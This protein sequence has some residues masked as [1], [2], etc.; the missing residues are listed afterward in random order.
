MMKTR[1]SFFLLGFSVFLLETFWIKSGLIVLGSTY[2]TTGLVLGAFFLGA[3][4]GSFYFGRAEFRP[5][6]YL[7]GLVGA[8][9][10]SAVPAPNAPAMFGAILPAC[11]L[12]A[13]LFPIAG[14]ASGGR[15]TVELYAFNALGAVIGILAG[16]Y[17]LPPITGYTALHRIGAAA[18]LLAV[19]LFVRSI[20][21]PRAAQPE[22]LPK[23]LLPAF[24][25][26]FLTLMM[27]NV[28]IRQIS[29]GT[30]N[31]VFAFGCVTL[32]FTLLSF[33]TAFTIARLAERRLFL[34][35]ALILSGLGLLAGAWL[36]SH[37]TDGLKT[38]V[39]D[40]TLGFPET[41][42]FAVKFLVPAMLFPLCVFPLILRGQKQGFGLLFA[43][44]GLGCALGALLGGFVFPSLIGMWGMVLAA[45]LIYALLSLIVERT[46]AVDAACAAA[47]V[48]ILF[49]HPVKLPKVTPDPVAAGYGAPACTLAV[50][51]GP[52]GV[53]SV[54]E[55]NKIRTLWLNST[56]VLGGTKSTA[57]DRRMGLFPV[58][59]NPEAK[60]ALFIGAAT[61]VSASGL[62]NSG[63]DSI[64]LVEL[65]PE[66]AWAARW[67]FA[68]SN[69]GLFSDP[70]V[71]ERVDDGRRFLARSK[72]KYDII[73]S[74]L[75]VPWH[76][77]TSFL[78]TKEHFENARARLTPEGVY[79][80]WLPL[81]EV[82]I[83]EFLIIGKTF[84]SVFPEATL[85]MNGFSARA[86]VI[87][88]VGG[89]KLDVAAIDS[90]IA[91]RKNAVKPDYLE[92]NPAG[93][94]S[95]YLGPLASLAPEME[96]QRVNTLDKPVLEYLAAGP[97]RVFVTE[98]LFLSVLERINGRE[99][100][101]DGKCFTDWNGNM[102]RARSAG[103]HMVRSVFFLMNGDREQAYMHFDQ[104]KAMMPEVLHNP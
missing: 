59:L 97:G 87:A 69:R 17:Y 40:R 36:F 98:G 7:A 104:Y 41:F 96:F 82:T 93:L 74:D 12:L 28:W 58:I 60:K 102:A 53:V 39:M 26:G 25:S 8:L 86:P 30:D 51:E 34:A 61:G 54:I 37:L 9:A 89:R 11:F 76:E 24:L 2:K 38:V 46:L 13:A 23:Y 68:D 10:L 88:F 78:Y 18:A 27:E 57:D 77:G 44:N 63:L 91:A 1:L 103:W 67:Y 65:I 21:P 83:E 73:T 94:Y 20:E 4:L 50:K 31:T 56:Y 43:V 22:A 32:L 35:F 72:D 15:T 6:R 101:P 55:F 29:M 3:A 47:L 19:L 70:R 79:V 66:V 95:R 33:I 80:M 5:A 64:T 49:F 81:Y 45:G 42:S 85:W 48:L 92:K 75:F 52:Y 71:K 99:P 16:V 84:G 100:D 90:G 14:R 62:L